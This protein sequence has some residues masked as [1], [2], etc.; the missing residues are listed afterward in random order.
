ML[1]DNGVAHLAASSAARRFILSPRYDEVD[2]EDVELKPVLGAA[3]AV[4]VPRCVV[5]SVASDTHL[6]ISPPPLPPLPPSHAGRAA[7]DTSEAGAEIVEDDRDVI[8]G[9]GPMNL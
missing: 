4:T 5:H 1:V 9:A 3:T 8:G 2:E 6:L 7:H